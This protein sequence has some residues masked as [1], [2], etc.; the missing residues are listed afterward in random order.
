MVND[1]RLAEHLPLSHRHREIRGN[2]DYAHSVFPLYMW[3]HS[4][5]AFQ[6]LPYN[7]A[8]SG[9]PLRATAF[10]KWR[11][12]WKA[13]TTGVVSTGTYNDVFEKRGQ[14]WKVLSRVSRDDPNWPLYLFAPYAANEKSLYRSSCGDT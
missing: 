11:V 6:I 3:R 4:V 12:D 14:E 7:N 8:S 10:W 13:N 5:G 2:F 1:M 9:G